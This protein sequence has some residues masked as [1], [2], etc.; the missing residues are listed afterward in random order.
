MLFSL[1]NYETNIKFLRILGPCNTLDKCNNFVDVSNVELPTK[2][3]LEQV[4]SPIKSGTL[5]NMERNCL[6]Q[7]HFCIHDVS[8]PN[9]DTTQLKSYSR[10]AQEY[11]TLH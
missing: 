1:A 11:T 10:Q 3:I 5:H 7:T 2:A 8:L 4:P 9:Q 6:A